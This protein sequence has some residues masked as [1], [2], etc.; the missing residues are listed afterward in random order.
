MPLYEY[1]CQTCEKVTEEFQ[2]MSDAPL[3]ICESCD[4]KLER[5]VGQ[6]HIGLCETSMLRAA[7]NSVE[8]FNNSDAGDRA[9]VYAT[10]AKRAGVSMQGKWYNPALALFVGDPMAWVGS[11][12]D[13]KQVCKARGW[14][15][16]IRDG[17]FIVQIPSDFSKLPAEL[18]QG[19]T[20]Q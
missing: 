14:S 17:E 5:L 10:N 6:V 2:S 9:N 19:A 12:D 8:Q 11:I 4:G 18:A 20:C 13:Q 16:V 7:H 3:V 15:W 1:Q